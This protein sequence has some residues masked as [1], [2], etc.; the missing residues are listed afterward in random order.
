MENGIHLLCYY[1]LNDK[2]ILRAGILY[3]HVPI[4]SIERRNVYSAKYPSSLFITVFLPHNICSIDIQIQGAHLKISKMKLFVCVV[5]FTAEMHSANVAAFSPPSPVKRCGNR[6]PG[7]HFLPDDVLEASSQAIMDFSSLSNRIP[8]DQMRNSGLSV[9]KRENGDEEFNAP[10]LLHQKASL[11][12]VMRSSKFRSSFICEEQGASKYFLRAIDA[13]GAEDHLDN[14]AHALD[15]R[16]LY[17][18]SVKLLLDDNEQCSFKM[19]HQRNAL[20]SLMKSKPFLSSLF[21]DYDRKIKPF[22]AVVTE[23]DKEYN[24]DHCHKIDTRFMYTGS[25]G[26]VAP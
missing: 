3:H 24:D 19:L 12:R 25:V 17:T 20:M 8:N 2:A 13:T 22:S 14:H 6:Y 7:L 16:L 5:L 10:S 11:S 18:G 9:N 15:S 4:I 21:Q 1:Y 23:K 26:R